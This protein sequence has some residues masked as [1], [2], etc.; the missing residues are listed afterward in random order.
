MVRKMKVMRIRR[1]LVVLL[2]GVI[3]NAVFPGCS[4]NTKVKGVR[5]DNDGKTY[6]AIQLP[7]GKTKEDYFSIGG[8]LQ[9]TAV[10]A[11]VTDHDPFHTVVVYLYETSDGARIAVSNE[12]KG[13]I[14]Y[15]PKGFSDERLKMLCS[16]VVLN[17]DDYM[18]I[19]DAK[20]YIPSLTE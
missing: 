18:S 16:S 1:I 2:I 11:I 20:A 19:E 9:Q 4:T 6:Y 13:K 7:S 12:D 3:M 10:N 17:S 14:L 5:T 8:L 15:F